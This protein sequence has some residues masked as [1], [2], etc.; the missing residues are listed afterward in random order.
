MTNGKVEAE[1]KRYS[2]PDWI[3][4]ATLPHTAS[5]HGRS[6]VVVIGITDY[7]YFAQKSV[8]RK[9]CARRA[10]H[11]HFFAK[12]PEAA[13]LQ[14]VDIFKAAIPSTLWHDADTPTEARRAWPILPPGAFVPTVTQAQRTELDRSVTGYGASNG[15]D[16]AT[17]SSWRW[18]SHGTRN[19]S[20]VPGSVVLLAPHYRDGM[21]L[22]YD[23]VREVLR[24]PD[25]LSQPTRRDG[26]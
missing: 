11:R 23:D 4:K 9:Y 22:I 12:G 8:D 18:R 5:G 6:K 21:E 7:E 15:Q 26:T 16:G 10:G 3:G 2:L 20:P 17:A 14:V 24:T 13:V 19:R 25:G 1:G